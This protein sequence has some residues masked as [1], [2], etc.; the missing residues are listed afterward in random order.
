MDACDVVIVGGGPAGSSCAWALRD[1][2][3]DVLVVDR[4]TFPR[5]KLCGGWITPL[6]LDELEIS[7]EDYAPG[8]TMQPITGFRLSAIGGLQVEV[9]GDHIVSYGIRRCEFDEYL[10]R[11]S[12]ARIREGVPLTSI[13]RSDSGWL[14][15]GDTRAHV[16][17][18]AG[19]HFCPVGSYL[20]NKGSPAP[21]LAQEIEFEMDASQ[22]GQS[23]VAGEIPE[24][25]FCRDMLG[26]GWVFRKDNYLNVGLGRTDS[27]EISRHMKDFVGYLAK[28]RAVETPDT[29]ISG[30]AYGLF[31]RS[32]RNVLDDGV[33]LIGDAAGLAYAESGEG[34]RP[35]IESGLIAAHA[36]LAADGNYNANKLSLYRELVNSR[37]RREHSRI[38]TLSQLLP[39]TIKEMLGRQLLRGHVF[40][41]NVVMDQWFL[42]IAEQRLALSPQPVRHEM[43]AF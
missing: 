2:G 15:N 28:T 34:I 29:G 20:G 37:L 1:S 22:A 21:V 18:G 42:R 9:G 12:G 39:H 3:L 14:I 13:E 38:D 8:R 7:P 26:Y 27:R 10:L 17:I 30:H 33:L 16:L 5:H 41:R 4:A 32:Q 36:I 24:L 23:K 6:V 31:G 35:A 11:R 43:T 19:G 25:F 40:C